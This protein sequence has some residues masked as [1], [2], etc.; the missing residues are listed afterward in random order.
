MSDAQSSKDIDFYI[1]QFN[2]WAK[3]SRRCWSRMSVTQTP[4]GGRAPGPD[5]SFVFGCYNWD[6]KLSVTH[7][8]QDETIEAKTLWFRSLTLAER[9]DMLCAFTELLLLTNP[10]I[11]EQRD[12]KPVEGRILVLT[13]R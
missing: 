12:A 5:S 1:A 3:F 2:S 6:M 11:V 4:S 7:D 9:M 10:K 13:T 8:R